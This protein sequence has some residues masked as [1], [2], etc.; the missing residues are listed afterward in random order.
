MHSPNVD[1]A[2]CL[3]IVIVL[4]VQR[5]PSTHIVEGEIEKTYML[6]GEE[7]DFN[8]AILRHAMVRFYSQ[9]SH[10]HLLLLFQ[11]YSVDSMINNIN[12]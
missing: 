11:N 1:N 10:H 3:P 9:I 4:T 2:I 12:Y 5:F 8:K 7:V 6:Q